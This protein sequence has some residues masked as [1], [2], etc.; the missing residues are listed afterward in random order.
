MKVVITGGNGYLGSRLS[1]YLTEYGHEITAICYPEIPKEKNWSEMVHQA[2]IGDITEKPVIEMISRLNAD[3]IIHLVSLDHHQSEK[4]PNFVSQINV[5]PTWNLLHKCTSKGL[6][7]FIY[8]S[9]IHIYG[10]NQSGNIIENQPPTPF[11][12]YGLTHHLSEEICNY[13]NRKT[14]AKCINI[15]LSNSYGEPVF[16]DANC[17]SL[18]VNDLT[19]SALINKKIILKSD[20]SAVRD[21]I[22]YSDICEGVH[23]LLISTEKTESNTMHFSSS[24]SISMLDV[25]IKIRDI[26][27]SRYKHEIPIYINENKRWDGKKNTKSTVNN[28]VSN[29]LAKS[30]SIEF[31][32]K[33][34]SG[35]EDLFTYL[36]KN[37]DEFK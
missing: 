21:F 12:A 27:L 29:S 10:K 32:K 9:T 22:H 30:L 11:N 25:A 20:G 17:W 6:K 8:F 3:A 14:T 34:S 2:I 4:D 31:Q 18:I 13:Y 24:R 26:Y 33:L 19:R 23:K 1:K 28:E 15:R 36:E 5:Q 7:K 35:I 37:Y 16:S